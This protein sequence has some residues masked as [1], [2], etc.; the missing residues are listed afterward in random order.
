MAER[1]VIEPPAETPSR[2][3]VKVKPLDLSTLSPSMRE[4]FERTIAWSK[5]EEEEEEN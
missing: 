1:R 3:P 2:E 5:Q 4:S